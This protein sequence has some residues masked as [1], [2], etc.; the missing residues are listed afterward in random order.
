MRTL[1]V[2]EKYIEKVKNLEIQSMKDNSKVMVVFFTV[3]KF[4][5]L[6]V[7]KRIY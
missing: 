5:A 2:F 4:C 1:E 6:Q 3:S 7:A